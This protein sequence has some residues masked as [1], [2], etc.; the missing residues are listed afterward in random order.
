MREGS[1]MDIHKY[2]DNYCIVMKGVIDIY[3]V[4][5][6]IDINYMCNQTPQRSC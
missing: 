1:L 5:E 4:R 2:P 3:V 6:A